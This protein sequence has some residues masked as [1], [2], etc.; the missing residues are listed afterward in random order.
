VLFIIRYKDGLRAEMFA[1]NYTVMH[2]NAAWRYAKNGNK[3]STIFWLADNPPFATFAAQ[4][5][6]IEEMYLTGK[7]TWPTERTLLSSGM[8]DAGLTSLN[9]DCR[10][11][12]TPY[13]AK[14]KYKTDFDWTQP[15]DPL[16]GK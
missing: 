2:W 12:K 8:L 11:V 15:T 4:M 3:D 5:K 1:L 10:L 16:A 14:I 7:P 6:G 13:M 9:E